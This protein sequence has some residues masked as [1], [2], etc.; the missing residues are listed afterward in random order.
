MHFLKVSFKEEEKDLMNNYSFYVK[1]ELKNSGIEPVIVTEEFI[2]KFTSHFAININNLGFF[3]VNEDDKDNNIDLNYLEILKK[4]ANNKINEFKRK[5]KSLKK[6]SESSSDESDEYEDSQ[7]NLSSEYSK[8][9][10]SSITSSEDSKN[11]NV[12]KNNNQNTKEK[13]NTI[14]LNEKKEEKKENNY[15]SITNK[16]N[17]Y[18][19]NEFWNK[20]SKKLHKKGVES[21]NYYSVNLSHVKLMVFDYYKDCI[22]EGNKKEIMLLNMALVFCAILL[23]FVRS[24]NGGRIAWHYMIGII[25]SVTH[26]AT[27]PQYKTSAMT[28]AII[29]M[30]LVLYL[31][32]LTSWGNNGYLIL[33]PYKSFFTNG[34]REGDRCHD[35]YEYDFYY[36]QDKFYK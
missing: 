31:R 7:D 8:E 14:I 3:K 22:V 5:M 19:N 23:V 15:I 36:D 27:N 21:D 24:E 2:P 12:N 32:I 13:N 30:L 26:L 33:Y 25:A 20:S 1:K 28:G 35:V 17:N 34:V 16:Y 11:E 9:S 6:K 10:S 29:V 4:E 18:I